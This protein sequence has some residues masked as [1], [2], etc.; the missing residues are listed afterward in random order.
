MP[1]KT[2]ARESEGGWFI[3]KTSGGKKESFTL[4]LSDDQSN[5]KKPDFEI[6]NLKD[7]SLLE[8][9]K[10]RKG[11]PKSKR[12]KRKT[13]DLQEVDG[14]IQAVLQKKAKVRST[15]LQISNVKFED[16][17][18]NDATLKE[19]CKM[20]IHMRHPEVYQHLGVVPPRGVLLHGPPGCGK[21]LLAHAIAGELD[22][23][24]LKVAAPEI[25][26]GVSGES[27]Q[28]LRDLFDQAVI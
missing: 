23:P 4:D 20:L 27:E 12:N 28:K 26:S 21:T 3:D 14:E 10:K 17:G 25:V 19:V 5:Y 9:D 18:G 22:L 15:E 8:S 2:P 6:Q 16:I 13:E 1:V 24:I 11:R 7:S